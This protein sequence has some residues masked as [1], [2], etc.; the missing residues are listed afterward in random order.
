MIGLGS[1]NERKVF[2]KFDN[3]PSIINGK[4]L[5]LFP[6][7]DIIDSYQN[8][9]TSIGTREHTNEINTPNIYYLTINYRT[10]RH[11]KAMRY[12]S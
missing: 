12:I 10:F 5:H 1:Q 8:V 9:P 4:G 11:F 2:S 3:F 6:L 7:E